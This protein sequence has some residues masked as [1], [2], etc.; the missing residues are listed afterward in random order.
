MTTLNQL[1][2]ELPPERQAK[3]AARTA[4]LIAEEMTLRQL[5]QAHQLTQEHMAERLN[6]RQETVSRLE[7]RA[8]LLL[9]TLG[10]YVKATGGE[11]KLVA[12][13]PDRPPV[14]L[15][16]FSSLADQTTPNLPPLSKSNRKSGRRNPGRQKV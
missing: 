8:D 14:I 5:R 2:N 15:S 7:Q 4:E 1:L 9:S 10:S 16:G 6:V 11:L 12:E 13:F 3:I